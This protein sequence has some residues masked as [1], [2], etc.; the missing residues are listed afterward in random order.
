MTDLKRN[1]TSGRHRHGSAR[2]EWFNLAGLSWRELARKTWKEAQNDAVLNRAAELA[3]WFLLGFFPMLLFILEISTAVASGAQN[4]L[5][6]YLNSVLPGDTAKL[7]G[8][9]LTQT[10]G[11]GRA[12]LPLLFALWSA[13]SATDGLIETLNAIYDLNESRPIWKRRLLALVLAV[14]MGVL[15]VVALAIVIYGNVVVSWIGSGSVASLW[16]IAHYPA[17]VCLLILALLLVY[18]YAPDVDEQKWK[19][20]LP[21]SIIASFTWLVTS[22]L[23]RL[24]VDHFSNF[25]LLY[26]SLG[27]LIILMFW[28]YLSGIVILV[29]GEINA[30]IEATAAQRHVPGAKASGQRSLA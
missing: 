13:S 10:T 5:M 22:F 3:F 29:G 18:R 14:G 8:G 6:G 15:I 9:I 2:L 27:T 1:D 30:I 28:F 16:K 26:G 20:L 4:M 12:W 19:W 17:A 24:Y 23:F 11:N 21:G 25:G 7:V